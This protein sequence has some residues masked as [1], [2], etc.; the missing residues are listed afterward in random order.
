MRAMITLALAVL[1]AASCAESKPTSE[2]PGIPS[3]ETAEPQTEIK[4]VSYQLAIEG[5]TCEHCARRV[6]TILEEQP[7]VDGVEVDHANG[8]ASVKVKAGATLD[9]A[10]VREA[11]DKDMYKL[12]ACTISN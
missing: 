6:K 2:Q 12:T 8:H 5:M 3:I 10:A 11:L 9:E 4:P 7:G 1:F